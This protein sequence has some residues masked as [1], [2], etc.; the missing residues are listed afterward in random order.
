MNKTQQLLKDREEQLN[1]EIASL[2]I[3]SSLFHSQISETG[4]KTLNFPVYE[5][6]LKDEIDKF[7]SFHTT[8]ISLLL[9]SL[10]EEI[11][12]ERDIRIWDKNGRELIEK[13]YVLTLLS[14]T[15][16]NLNK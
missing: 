9:N 10:K 15:I 2:L 4:G 13:D 6:N 14:E 16:S 3:A 7:K 5:E 12:K 8:T 1:A 11:T